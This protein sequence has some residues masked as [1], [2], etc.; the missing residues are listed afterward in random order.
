MA[1]G[2]SSCDEADEAAAGGMGFM[3]PAG[4]IFL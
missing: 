4:Q 2:S 1:N 3:L